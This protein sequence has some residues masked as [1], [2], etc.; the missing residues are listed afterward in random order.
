MKLKRFL[1]VY[2]AVC[3]LIVIL[4]NILSMFERKGFFLISDSSYEYSSMIDGKELYT[5]SVKANYLTKI[6]KNSDIYGLNLNTNKRPNFII[7][8]SQL[9][10]WSPYC[11]IIS[12]MVLE[13]GQKIDFYYNLNVKSK[14]ISLYFILPLFFI[15]FFCFCIYKRL[16]NSNIFMF[17]LLFFISSLCYF[18]ASIALN[19]YNMFVYKYNIYD[20]LIISVIG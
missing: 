7:S 9:Q 19:K 11:R 4:L 15:I 8:Y 1:I 17:I 10:K 14:N 5:Y 12:T 20:N 13:N 3:A 6:F 2:C 16:I 18:L